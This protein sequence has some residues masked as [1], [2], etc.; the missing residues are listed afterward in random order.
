MDETQMHAVPEAG[1]SPAATDVPA[2]Y[3]S[4]LAEEPVMALDGA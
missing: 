4:H 2:H 1:R 3:Q